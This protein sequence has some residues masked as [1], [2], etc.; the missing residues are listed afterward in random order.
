[1]NA[2]CRLGYKVSGGDPR[3]TQCR[4]A[5]RSQM[6]EFMKSRTFKAFEFELKDPQ[7]SISQGHVKI[8]P[9]WG[10]CSTE[11][12]TFSQACPLQS[13]LRD[14][15]E[16][17]VFCV[18]MSA[19]TDLGAEMDAVAKEAFTFFAFENIYYQEQAAELVLK[20]TVNFS[21]YARAFPYECYVLP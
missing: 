3:G 16:V 7:R 10:E 1:M 13:A 9:T 8:H 5:N 19:D 12:F 21:Q 6:I 2:L 17:S 15:V 18:A 20:N 14:E 11:S 4:R